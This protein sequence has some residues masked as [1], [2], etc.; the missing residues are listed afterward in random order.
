M[1]KRKKQPSPKPA[2]DAPLAVIVQANPLYTHNN[3]RAGKFYESLRKS[4]E[5]KGWRVETDPGEPYT[6]P[7]RGARLWI[8]HSRGADRLKYAP[9]RIRTIDLKDLSHGK[10]NTL[11]PAYRRGAKPN[12]FHYVLTK[13]MREAIPEAKE[14]K[15]S[16]LIHEGF[17]TELQR[18]AGNQD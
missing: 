17:R 1:A 12:A 8:G 7:P 5:R 9:E 2:P 18:L 4:L 6:S 14:V 16:S 11:H 10:D 3:S 15:V 13:K